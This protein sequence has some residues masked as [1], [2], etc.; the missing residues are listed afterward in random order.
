[1]IPIVFWTVVVGSMLIF[2]RWLLIAALDRLVPKS[3]PKEDPIVAEAR[4]HLQKVFDEISKEYVPKADYVVDSMAE[5]WFCRNPT[6]GVFNG[7]AK[8]FHLTCRT[9]GSD[10]PK[11]S[12]VRFRS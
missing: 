12:T 8:E 1:M 2:C 10:R 11:S 7:D 6:C 5:G 9:C 3:H 4:K